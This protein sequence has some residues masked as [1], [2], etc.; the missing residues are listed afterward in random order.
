MGS[1]GQSIGNGGGGGGRVNIDSETDVWS[2]RHNSGNVPFV[3]AMNDGVRR[4]QNDFPDIMDDVNYVM[5][6]ELKGA[7]KY[8]ILGY[9]DRTSKTVA[10]NTNFTD[11]DKMNAVY[12]RSTQQG[13]HP[14]RGSRSG[15]EAVS[16][17][18]MGHAL[19]DYV[20]QKMG[21]GDMDRAA[22]TLVKAAYKASGAKGGNYKWGGTI[23][24]YAQT[25][26]TECVAEAV[27]DY[28]CN[29]SKA[30]NA[31]KAIMNEIFKYK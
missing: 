19:T 16:L 15:T 11:V 7:S 2:Y 21:H 26:Y 12:D 24:E 25:K 29:G 22:N 9:Y 4:I 31:S 1:R 30:S 28:Y 27:A 5:A 14:S 13:F 8:S 6:A 18:E 10:L 3:D 23:S 17:H 20:A